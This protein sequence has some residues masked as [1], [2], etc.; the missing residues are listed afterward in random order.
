[1]EDLQKVFDDLGVDATV[2]NVAEGPTFERFEVQVGP[3][4]KANKILSLE[5]H[6]SYHYGASVKIGNIPGRRA[7]GI[8]VSSEHGMVRLR[9]IMAAEPD[10]ISIG[11]SI[12]GAVV[13]SLDDLPH[14]IVAGVTGSGKSV[15]VNSIICEMIMKNQPDQLR[16]AMID[17]KRVELTKYN[18]IPHLMGDVVTKPMQADSLLGGLVQEMS[19][20]YDLMNKYGV[21]HASDIDLPSIVVVIDELADLMMVSGKSVESNIVRMAQ[22][23]RAASMH[24]IIATQRPSVDVL[25]GL[26]KAN[27]PAR[28]AFRTSSITDSRVILDQK[29]AEG[30]LGRGDALYRSTGGSLVRVQAPYV[31]DLEIDRLVRH[32]TA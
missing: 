32:W 10:A 30:L 19:R 22:L 9:E 13:S 21:R 27:L 25:T 1:M 14:M 7:I 2:I 16:L 29:G 31:S 11:Q 3:G 23:A 28:L 12:D 6:L 18:G 5:K 26:I 8:E 20:R 4:T 17:P 15:F 24:L